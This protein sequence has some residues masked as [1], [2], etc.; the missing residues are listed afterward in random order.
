[1]PLQP[2]MEAPP[3]PMPFGYDEKDYY[4]L[5]A[6]PSRGAM[7]M[8]VTLDEPASAA[9]P[10]EEDERV[11]LALLQL[12]ADAADSC[13]TSRW[14]HRRVAQLEFLDTRAVRWRISV[15]FTVPQM[16]PK[17][18]RPPMAPDVDSSPLVMVPIARWRKSKLVKMDFRDEQG[19]AIPLMTAEENSRFMAAALYR[20]AAA[21]LH[22]GRPEKLAL[23]EISVP[24]LTKIVLEAPDPDLQELSGD[25]RV[26]ALLKRVSNNKSQISDVLSANTAFCSMLYE[27]SENSVVLALVENRPGTRRILKLAFESAVI[28][29]SPRGWRRNFGQTFGLRDWRLEVMLGGRGGSGHMEVAAPAGVDISKIIAK[30]TFG[31]PQEPGQK[32]R[33]KDAQAPDDIVAAGTTP[34]V[35]LRVPAGAR[36][37]RATIYL[38]VSPTGWLIGSCLV[39][40]VIFGSMLVGRAQ[41]AAVFSQKSADVPGT[42]ATLLLALLGIVATYL[43]RPGMHPLATRLLQAARGLIMAD[44]AVVLVAVGDLLLHS[45]KKVPRPI[46][47]GLTIFSGLVWLVLTASL[48]VPWPWR[49]VEPQEGPH[50]DATVTSAGTVEIEQDPA[51]VPVQG[52]DGRS[53]GDEY[54]WGADSQR[55]LVTKLTAVRKAAGFL[56]G[57]DPGFKPRWDQAL[58]IPY[59]RL[60][61]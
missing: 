24:E 6:T 59:A 16:A 54:A 61:R 3:H 20:W 35:A 44:V 27:L 22:P 12:M 1:V 50:W 42:A 38:R 30:P 29:Q 26:K 15:D 4:L 52:P 8:E 19:A 9:A 14:V 48:L 25:V 39:A 7:D 34:H 49:K 45:G 5:G 11:G 60:R 21:I 57:R 36:R 18:D 46:W 31:M 2:G 43:I 40:F 33:R 17:I 47:D 10:R 56:P 37:F 41:I 58:P 51:G 53:Y 55:D 23:R 28:F 32:K 13:P